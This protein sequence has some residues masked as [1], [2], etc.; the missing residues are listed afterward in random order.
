MR[1]SNQLNKKELAD[2]SKI[3]LQKVIILKLA[4]SQ[5]A[6]KSQQNTDLFFEIAIVKFLRKKWFLWSSL[7]I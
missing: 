3:K 2:L 7:K 1:S 4:H 6:K 5:Q